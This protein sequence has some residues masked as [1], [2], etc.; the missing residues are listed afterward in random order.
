MEL[1]MVQLEDL[2]SELENSIEQL[3]IDYGQLIGAVQNIKNEMSKVQ[4]KVQRS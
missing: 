4:E 3:K 1:E 2:V